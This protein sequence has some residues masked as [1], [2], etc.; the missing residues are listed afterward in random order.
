METSKVHI[1]DGA[2]TI[3]AMSLSLLWKTLVPFAQALS[4]YIWDSL[5]IYVASE[6]KLDD[7]TIREFEMTE[8]KRV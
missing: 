2:E 7:C 8:K 5:S 1:S 4:I 3:K 6:V